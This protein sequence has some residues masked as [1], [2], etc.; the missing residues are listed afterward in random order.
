MSFQLDPKEENRAWREGQRDADREYAKKQK[1]LD[2]KSADPP[3][4]RNVSLNASSSV[5]SSARREH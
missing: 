4:R 1:S 3:S 5:V 2:Q